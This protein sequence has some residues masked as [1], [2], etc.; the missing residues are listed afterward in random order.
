MYDFVVFSSCI[1]D[2]EKNA[3]DTAVKHANKNIVP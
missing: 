1:Y 2:L 3:M